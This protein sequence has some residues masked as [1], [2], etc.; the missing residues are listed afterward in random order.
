MKMG[1]NDSK[2]R[3]NKSVGSRDIKSWELAGSSVGKYCWLIG[4]AAHYVQIEYT[5]LF[6]YGMTDRLVCLNAMFIWFHHGLE[7][8]VTK[9]HVMT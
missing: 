7:Q 4:T 2:M 1:L 8:L 9:T 6:V 5:A 3:W